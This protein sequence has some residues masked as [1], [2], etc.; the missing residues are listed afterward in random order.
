[1]LPETKTDTGYE[2]AP[3][4]ARNSDLMPFRLTRSNEQAQRIDN[5]PRI[6]GRKGMSSEEL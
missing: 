4:N 1:M 5:R 2:D 6:D 3:W